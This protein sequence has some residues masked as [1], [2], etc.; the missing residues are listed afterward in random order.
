MVFCHFLLSLFVGPLGFIL[1][2]ERKGTE[3]QMKIILTLLLLLILP[4]AFAN[5]QPAPPQV[6][7]ETMTLAIYFAL[8]QQ[9]DVHETFA[10]RAEAANKD[11]L[12]R[13]RKWLQEQTGLT[14][15]EYSKVRPVALDAIVAI[16]AGKAQ[17]DAAFD[18]A[19]NQN[20]GQPLTDA[21]KQAIGAIHA[22]SERLVLAH[23]QQIAAALGSGRFQQFDSAVRKLI[24][25]SVKLIP[26]RS[27]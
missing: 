18:Q 8:L 6:S 11:P 7:A 16:K 15:A 1:L 2:M 24:G 17:S 13:G 21:Q 23:V 27:K 22:Q 3:M 14:D 9:V 25:P 20:Q 4:L 10:A 19:R 12:H 26:L 5:A